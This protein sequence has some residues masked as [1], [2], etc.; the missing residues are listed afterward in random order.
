MFGGNGIKDLPRYPVVVYNRNANGVTY[1]QCW[2]TGYCEKDK[3]SPDKTNCGHYPNDCSFRRM[4]NHY[5][6]KF[7]QDFDEIW[8]ELHKEK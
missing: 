4:S 5:Q 1:A 3:N 6:L 2:N 7:A 8:A